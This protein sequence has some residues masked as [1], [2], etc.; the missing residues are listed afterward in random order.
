[1]GTLLKNPITT[2]EALDEVIQSRLREVR[3][4]AEQRFS[5]WIPP[6]EVEQIRKD[7]SA[8]LAEA[9]QKR[10]AAEQKAMETERLYTNDRFKLMRMI[11]AFEAGLPNK[12][13]KYIQGEN[14]DDMR[15]DAAEL[16]ADFNPP[17]SV[18]LGS[19]DPRPPADVMDPKIRKFADAL[20]EALDNSSKGG[21]QHNGGWVPLDLE[22]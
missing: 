6:E 17:V 11:A 5:G 13:S 3:E 19:P 8:K 4:E 22:F 9:E 7:G 20:G 14:M 21:G 18:P 15:Q 16:A 10:E 1:M 12:Y 2:Q